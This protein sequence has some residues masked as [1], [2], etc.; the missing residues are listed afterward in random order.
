LKNFKKSA[1]NR[2]SEKYDGAVDVKRLSNFFY[3]TIF[4]YYKVDF[5]VPVSS[6]MPEFFFFSATEDEVC[7][8]V[9]SIKSNAA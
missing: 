6:N 5:I 3:E 1:K 4:E 8:A 7:R 9:M 2:G